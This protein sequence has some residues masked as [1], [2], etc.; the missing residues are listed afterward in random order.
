MPCFGEL[1]CHDFLRAL[2]FPL[3]YR[4]LDR[5]YALFIH[6]KGM[7]LSDKIQWYKQSKLDSAVELL[8][9]KMLEIGHIFPL[10]MDMQAEQSA[11]W[12]RVRME[13]GLQRCI[14]DPNEL[15]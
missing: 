14:K 15:F 7:P 3:V 2:L 4:L 6:T 5:D 9:E 1:H 11:E 13:W 12:S 8:K 10:C